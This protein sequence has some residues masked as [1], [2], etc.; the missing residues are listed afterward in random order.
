[1]TWI[2]AAQRDRAA[3]PTYVIDA[4]W[5]TEE[6]WQAFQ[7]GLAQTGDA[8]GDVGAILITPTWTT[9]VWPHAYGMSRAPGS[10]CTRWK[11]VICH[12]SGAT[13]RR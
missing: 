8:V 5:G 7:G 9:T 10:A 3:A 1:M 6:A 13:P 12:G 2:A 11:P 4:G